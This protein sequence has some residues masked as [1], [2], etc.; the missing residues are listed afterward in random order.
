MLVQESSIGKKLVSPVSSAAHARTM[1]KGSA[2]HLVLNV[3]SESNPLVHKE[4][5]DDK[6]FS[7]FVS[8]S[9]AHAR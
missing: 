4:T 3:D 1:R 9:L 7:F 6:G 8:Y 2:D 5:D